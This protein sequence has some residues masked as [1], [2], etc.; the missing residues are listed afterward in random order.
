MV[1]WHDR[2]LLPMVDKEKQEEADIEIARFI[3]AVPIPWPPHIFHDLE[4]RWHRV[5]SYRGER[6]AWD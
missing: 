6:V 5:D 3:G 2:I 1:G 4:A